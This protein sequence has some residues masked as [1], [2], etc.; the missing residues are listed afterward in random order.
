MTIQVV[1][2]GRKM[3]KPQ[4]EKIAQPQRGM[5]GWRW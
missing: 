3:S 4:G 2:C 5:L 1:V